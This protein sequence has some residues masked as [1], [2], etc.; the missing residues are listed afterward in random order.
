[1]KDVVAFSIGV[2]ARLVGLIAERYAGWLL[3]KV[4]EGAELGIDALTDLREFMQWLLHSA[5]SQLS[6]GR[7]YA[8]GDYEDQFGYMR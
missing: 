1:M 8:Y 6:G 4:S 7:G 5:A 3:H 2:L